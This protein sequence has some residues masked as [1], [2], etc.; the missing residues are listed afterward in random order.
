M[1]HCNYVIALEVGFAMVNHTY[2]DQVTSYGKNRQKK[3]EYNVSKES[4]IS[5]LE[6]IIAQ[7]NY[8]ITRERK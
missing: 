5:E 3:I 6:T 4:R 8:I 1:I 2:S 7:R